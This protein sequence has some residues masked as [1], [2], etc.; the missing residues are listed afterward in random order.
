MGKTEISTPNKKHQGK[1]N[2]ARFQIMKS[3]NE[4]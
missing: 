1:N 3:K 2:K 4:I